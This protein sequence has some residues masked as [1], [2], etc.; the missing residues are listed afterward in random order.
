[1][2]SPVRP[3]QLRQQVSNYVDDSAKM[4]NACLAAARSIGSFHEIYA[5]ALSTDTVLKNLAVPALRPPLVAARSIILRV[6]MLASIGQMSLGTVELRRFLELTVW[7]VYFTD[8]PVEWRSFIGRSN[9]GF[10]QDVRKPIS[11]AARRELAHYIEYARE[12][13]SAEPS[14]LGTKAVDAI[15]QLTHDLNAAV[16]AGELAQSV[17]RI[18]PHEE[19]SR[20]VLQKFRRLQQRVFSNCCLLLAAYRRQQFDRLSATARAHFDW[21]VGAKLRREVRRGPFGLTRVGRSVR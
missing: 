2:T 12:L 14:G 3:Q 15:K 11:Y 20:I 4:I 8:H 21:L 16:H 1:M 6:P 10:S 5:T 7:T 18:P 17:K 19:V 13:M 9:A